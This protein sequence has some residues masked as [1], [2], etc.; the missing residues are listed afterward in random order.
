M[1]VLLLYLV[2]FVIG[3]ILGVAYGFDPISAVL[4]SVSCSACCG[5]SS[6]IVSLGMPLG[7]KICC[8]VQMLAGRLEFLTLFA[9][10]AS[11]GASLGHAALSSRAARGLPQLVPNGVR[12]A[13]RGQG[14]SGGDRR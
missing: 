7:L 14:T 12:R 9:T 3:A 6:G 5:F 13:W 11:I 8:F 2:S 4:E 1:L 10:I